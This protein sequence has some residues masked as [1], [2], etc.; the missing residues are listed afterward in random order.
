MGAPQAEAK[1]EQK[2]NRQYFVYSE[3][4]ST[5]E[6]VDI[7]SID[8]QVAVFVVRICRMSS[9]LLKAQGHANDW[10]FPP[11]FSCQTI[12]CELEKRTI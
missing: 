2:K 8:W 1:R 6:K 10:L 4:L 5:E 12:L 3:I 7:Q 9:E 11:I